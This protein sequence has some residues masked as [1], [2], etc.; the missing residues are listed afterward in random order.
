MAGSR[1]G[2]IWGLVAG[3]AASRGGHVTAA[4]VC[5][6]AVAA[7]EVSGAWLSAATGAEAGHLIQVT[8]DVSEQLAELELTLGE[9]PCADVSASGG[10]MLAS[11][12]GETETAGRWPVFAPAAR[13][14]GAGAIFAFPLRIGAIRAGVMGL[15]RERPGPLSAAQLGDA[16]IFAD[17]A[18]LLL[19][20]SQDQAA[21]GPPAGS[22]PGGQ[23]AP[24]PC[25]APRSIRPPACSPSSSASASRRL[26]SGYVPTHTLMTGGWP[27]LPAP[28]W[29]AAC[30]CTVTQAH[31]RRARRERL[32]V[33]QRAH[34]LPRP[35]DLV[36]SS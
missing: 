22:G 6:A 33:R 10:P 24:W 5:A 27:M 8:D 1:P 28:S 9:G 4:D 34:R 18:T 25:T 13:Q 29:R 12:L 2:R 21:G 19:L 15:Y 35:A 16:L 23:P 30:G 36:A 3:Q 14:A 32:H 26:L 17:T 11:D 31:P 7:V 20:D